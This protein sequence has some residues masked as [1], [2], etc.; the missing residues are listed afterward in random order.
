MPTALARLPALAADLVALKP[1]LV[2]AGSAAG[3]LAAHGA[4]QTIPIAMFSV[5]DPVALG[6]VKSI[7]RP[8]GNVTGIW[9][10]GGDDALV[11]KRIELL[12]EIVPALS[13]MGVMV[14]SGDPSDEI[15]LRLLPAATRGL[16]V[17]YK[18]FDARTT[19]ELDAAFAQ[20]TS[21]GMQAIF[22]NQNPLMFSRRAEIAALA[23]RAPAGY[24]RLSRARRGRRT[25]LVWLQLSRRLPPVRA[26]GGQDLEG[27]KACRSADRAADQV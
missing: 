24:L 7:A 23:A 10:F 15:I 17:S 19:A 6:V 21:E 20:A 14:S 12:K 16:G 11:G 25:D 26:A 3:I 18:V 2:I 9:M 13:R 5:L 1:D 27:G 4:T 8:G 22:I